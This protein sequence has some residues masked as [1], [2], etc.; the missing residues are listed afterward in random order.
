NH[1][2]IYGGFLLLNP[3]PLV[4]Y[5][6][7]RETFG[8]PFKNGFCLFKK[9]ANEVETMPYKEVNGFFSKHFTQSID[10]E[11]N[12]DAELSDFERF[13][14]MVSTGKDPLYEDLTDNEKD[15]QGMFFNMFGYLCHTYKDPS[16]SPAIILSDEGADDQ[17]RNG[18][19]GKSIILKALSY[20]QNTL[21]KG[22]N[23]FDGNYRHRFADLLKEYK[24]YAIDD[25][26][27]G[28]KYD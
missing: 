23:E 18:G 13:L 1:S 21:I 12:T 2:I 8:I 11:F 10:F 4:Y 19:R 16:F 5:S 25:V 17:N 28:F 15:V 14:T 27:A 26:P 7:K 22:G 20:V 6:D 9:G 24:I 3:K